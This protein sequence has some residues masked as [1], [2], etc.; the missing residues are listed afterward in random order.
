MRIVHVVRQFHPSVGGL[1]D[2]VHNLANEQVKSGGDV[3]V[4]T[5]NTDFQSG[6]V[7][8]SQE[9]LENGV[10]ILRFKWVGSSRYPI[11]NIPPKLLNDFDVVHVHAV[12][13]FVEYTSLLKRVGLLKSKL[14]LTTHGG[15]FHTKNNS[16]LK[17]LFFKLVTPISLSEFDDVIC[18]SVND[19]KLFKKFPNSRIIENGVL[20]NK[21]GVGVINENK[22]GNDIVYLGR[23]SSNKNIPELVSQ[24]SKAV[25]YPGR[26]KI[27]GRSSSGDSETLRRLVSSVTNVDLLLDIDDCEISAILNES[28]FV[29]SASDYEGFGLGVIELMSYGLVP[30]LSDAPS[31]FCQFV[32]ESKAGCTFNLGKNELSGILLSLLDKYTKADRDNA[33]NY[34]SKFS[35]LSVSQEYQLV[36]QQK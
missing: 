28:K 32:R 5:L 12:D 34:A 6:N 25:D 7:L 24:F 16:R 14:V 3:S 20:P 26:L 19:F 15:F 33:L 1:E 10:K 8:K 2:F 22:K 30:V 18:C 23:L 27:I 13:F 17:M 11:C 35:W 31:T 9:C 4:F 21:F 36:Y 29:I